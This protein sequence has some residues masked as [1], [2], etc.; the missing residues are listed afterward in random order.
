[1]KKLLLLAVLLLCALVLTATAENEMWYAY[2]TEDGDILVADYTYEGTRISEL[3]LGKG[4]ERSVS[5]LGSDQVSFYATGT[6]YADIEDDGTLKAE[7]VG[8]SKLRVYVSPDHYVEIK[9]TVKK[10]PTSVTFDKSELTAVLGSK[11]KLSVTLSKNSA[12]AVTYESSDDSVAWMDADGWVHPVNEGTCTLTAT[13]YNGVKSSCNV[14]VILPEPAQVVTRPVT[15]YAFEDVVIPCELIGGYN[16]SVTCV[17]SDETMLTVS[18]DGTA[19][20]LKPGR[21]EVTVTASRGSSAV[22]SIEILPCASSVTPSEQTVYLY[23]GGTYNPQASTKGGSGAFTVKSSDETVAVTD[24]NTVTA[25][26]A[27]ECSLT[28][29]APGGANA[30]VTLHVVPM[31]GGLTVSYPAIIAAGEQAQIELGFAGPGMSAEFSSSNPSVLTVTADGRM[32]AVLPGEATVTVTCGNITRE[33]PVRV[34]FPADA[35]AFTES[36]AAMGLGDTMPLS[37]VL[38]GGSGQV[39]YVSSDETVVS[40][41]GDRL[42]A[43]GTGSATVTAQL[44]SGLKAELP[45]TVY[46]MPD[47]IFFEARTMTIGR[48]DSVTIDC[49]FP[50]GRYALLS[51]S[52]SD[53]AIVSVDESGRV[54]AHGID[55]IAAIEA[56][57]REGISASVNV[58]VSD[59]PEQ[60]GI[61]ADPIAQSGLF[62]H[63]LTL[64]PGTEYDLCITFPGYDR[65]SYSCTSHDPECAD[66]TPKGTVKA[67]KEGSAR[68]SV[69]VYNGRT[70]EILVE[71][72]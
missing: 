5:V 52:S 60:V 69:N 53:D 58:I 7:T 9:A 57:T 42:F 44:I 45:V 54:K 43:A 34:D 65:V 27:G 35:I 41:S 8:E 11:E 55:G 46:P 4:E 25:L 71:V 24:G 31:P 19:H 18:Q 2:L 1:M 56:R 36:E 33:I 32:E 38:S 16:E 64:K 51:R 20:C 6:Y 72:K 47:S 22:S 23:E 63:Y 30:V 29:T 26:R 49:I 15:G 12:G 66:V 3:T 17:S 28:L 59:S 21:C 68:I 67:L 70:L 14:T 39:T 48:G 61:N 50:A 37:V 62:T 10:A 40:V 13:A